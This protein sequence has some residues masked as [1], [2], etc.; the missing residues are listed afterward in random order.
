MEVEGELGR[1]E[2]GEPTI[3]CNVYKEL[4]KKKSFLNFDLH[5]IQVFSCLFYTIW[6]HQERQL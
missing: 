4:F 6:D 2:V 3:G 5:L 1:V